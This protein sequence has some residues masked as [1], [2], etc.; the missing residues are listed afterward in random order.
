MKRRAMNACRASAPIATESAAS[1]ISL[2]RSPMLR[3]SRNGIA[4]SPA[5]KATPIEHRDLDAAGTRFQLGSHQLDIVSPRGPN[6]PVADF[7]RTRSAGPYQATL[8]GGRAG[9]LDPS[10]T[11]N[12]RL[13]I[14]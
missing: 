6:G 1:R 14:Q 4:S 12:A 3:R 10:L 2:S 13:K 11:Q 5:V 7:L 9:E 8:N